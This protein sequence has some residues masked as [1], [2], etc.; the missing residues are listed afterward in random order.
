MA[1]KLSKALRGKH[2]WV[3]CK[4][5]GFQS[6]Q[7]LIAYVADLPLQLYDFSGGKCIFKVSLED[8]KMILQL[9]N[10]GRVLSMTSSGKIN[11]VRDRLGLVKPSRKR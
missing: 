1:R 2:R 10:E 3:G 6:R 9:F 11:L 7:D 4:C 5:I 8:H